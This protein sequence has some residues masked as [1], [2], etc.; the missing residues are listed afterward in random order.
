[1]PDYIARL[2]PEERYEKYD[3]LI[4][5]PRNDIRQS[6]MT[7]GK[8]MYGVEY[9]NLSKRLSGAGPSR[10]KWFMINCQT[11]FRKVLTL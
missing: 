4:G 2:I 3:S 6:W 7:S 8:S 11:E 9:D 5:P 1:M 10:S